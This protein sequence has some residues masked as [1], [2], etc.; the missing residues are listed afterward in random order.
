MIGYSQYHA[1]SFAAV[2]PADVYIPA[3][4]RGEAYFIT[5]GT[6]REHVHINDVKRDRARARKLWQRCARRMGAAVTTHARKRPLR[7]E[8]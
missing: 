4:V 8:A 1:R 3:R 2:R 7:A 5:R 6:D